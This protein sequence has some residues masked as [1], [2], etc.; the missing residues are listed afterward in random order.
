MIKS[1]KDHNC[2]EVV[3]LLARKVSNLGEEVNTANQH[4][5][6]LVEFLRVTFLA[7]R[8]LL[9]TVIPSH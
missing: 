8:G 2:L 7:L 5:Q 4:G 1:L 6:S 3:L 9:L